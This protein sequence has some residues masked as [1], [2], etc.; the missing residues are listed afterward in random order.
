MLPLSCAHALRMAADALPLTYISLI[1]S[2]IVL[3]MGAYKLYV[4]YGLFRKSLPPPPPGLLK[5]SDLLLGTHHDL[6]I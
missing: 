2:I 4:C 1:Y 5:P 6:R 3:F